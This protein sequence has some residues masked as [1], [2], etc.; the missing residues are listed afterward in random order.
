[1]EE[2]TGTQLCLVWDEMSPDSKLSVMRDIVSLESKMLS[3]SFSQYVDFLV[4][5]G[6]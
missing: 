3:V 6:M 5:P 1:M 2:A 4:D